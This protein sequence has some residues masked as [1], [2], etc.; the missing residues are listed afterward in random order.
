MTTPL[1]DPAAA[2]PDPT[3]TKPVSV[4]LGVLSALLGIV[5]P[6]AAILEKDLC[7]KS[8]FDPAPTRWHIALLLLVPLH[9]LLLLAVPPTRHRAFQLDLLGGVTLGIASVY[10]VIFAPLVPMGVLFAWMGIGLLPMAPLGAL[11]AGV[12]WQRRIYRS[13]TT[14]PGR[15]WYR[16]AGFRTGLG[17]ALGVLLL[18]GAEVPRL[19]T[20]HGLSLATS[21]DPV[22]VKRGVD[23]LRSWGNEQ[24]LLAASN[25]WGP[26][27]ANLLPNTWLPSTVSPDQAKQ[28]YYRVTGNDAEAVFDPDKTTREQRQSFDPHR[29]TSRVG[30][31]NESLELVGSRVDGSIN[32]QDVLGY[33][34]WTM[35]LRNYAAWAEAE[36]RAQMVLPPGAV[37]SRVTLFIDGEPHEAAFG[38]RRQVREAY[39]NVVRARRDPLLVTQVGPDRIALQCYPIP[40]AGKE[41]K[42]LIGLTFPLKLDSESQGRVVLPH[43]TARNFAISSSLSHRVWLE[44]KQPLSLA[45]RPVSRNAKGAFVLD[46]PMKGALEG[47]SSPVIQA[48]RS[49]ALYAFV[50]DP[51]TAPPDAGGMSVGSHLI[52]EQEYK[53]T[54][55]PRL[56][57]L[58]LVVDSSKSMRKAI[59]ELASALPALGPVPELKLLL[60]TDQGFLELKPEKPGDLR[61]LAEQLNDVDPQGGV[62]NLPAL[63]EAG[64]FVRGVENASVLWIHGPQPVSLGSFD[65]LQQNFERGP[66]MLVSSQVSAGEHVDL[67]E[68]GTPPELSAL[69]RRAT[70]GDD[71]RRQFH[72]W[73]GRDSDWVAVRTR[74]QV[75]ELPSVALGSGHLARLWAFDEI[76]RLRSTAPTEVQELA[77]SHRLVTAVSGAVVLES[78]AQYDAA[79]L[80]PGRGVASSPSVPEPE[81]W[82]LFALGL[83]LV[84]WQLKRQR[85]RWQ[86]A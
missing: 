46:A 13:A 41:M 29:G 25:S 53:K 72:R 21:S 57:R 45:G 67:T 78:A 81:T 63:V 55:F 31:V 34:E 85:S 79:K 70:L 37:V 69:P 10:S 82:A 23:L 2:L 15:A 60:A 24:E 27:R 18:L 19:V 14:F 43:L 38:G 7:T 52:I 28:V 76:N 51:S 16:R 12:L 66:F 64:S 47:E 71:L 8:F 44:S 86:T 49:G 84:L 65:A 30:P 33:V 62:D 26:R 40:P 4:W 74:R 42:I 77:V 50:E 80:E 54:S 22:E 35:V 1:P 75:A 20:R 17:V 6:V 39:R 11:V 83:G 32:A 59:P 56:Q 3:Q 58:A 48:Q 36:A 73:S 61:E 68:L 5:L 9:H